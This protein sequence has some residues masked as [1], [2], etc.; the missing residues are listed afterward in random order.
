LER[1]MANETVEGVNTL[2]AFFSEITSANNHLIFRRLSGAGNLPGLL[3]VQRDR[4]TEVIMVHLNEVIAKPELLKDVDAIIAPLEAQSIPE[5]YAKATVAKKPVFPITFKSWE[6]KV[7]RRLA[8][9]DICLPF[10]YI[11]TM[12]GFDFGKINALKRFFK[13]EAAHLSDRVFI[14][15]DEGFGGGKATSYY[16]GSLDN[17]ELLLKNYERRSLSLVIEPLLFEGVSPPPKT[18]VLKMH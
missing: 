2:I 14:K 13:R 1:L 4:D 11:P 5:L 9:K 18:R 16:L 15:E 6:S 3:D 8:L 10:A 7:I 12:R 17:L